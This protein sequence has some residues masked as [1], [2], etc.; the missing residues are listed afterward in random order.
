MSE[1][2]KQLDSWNLNTNRI[3]WSFAVPLLPNGPSGAW[4]LMGGYQ[5]QGIS[6]TI[7]QIALSSNVMNSFIMHGKFVEYDA[8]KFAPNLHMNNC[9]MSKI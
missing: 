1:E 3:N 6:L 9:K 4:E 2:R 8:I 5:L 7:L